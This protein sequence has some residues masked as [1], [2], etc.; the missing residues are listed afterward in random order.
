[1]EKTAQQR[2]GSYSPHLA[3]HSNLLH[4]YV[5]W[6]ASPIRSH[7]R[8]RRKRG[9]QKAGRQCGPG[10]ALAWAPT[11]LD[12]SPSSATN[13]WSS[14]GKMTIHNSGPQFP[15]GGLSGLHQQS[16]R[17]LPAWLFHAWA[18]PSPAHLS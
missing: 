4:V 1:M 9:S 7:P 8:T 15:L 3:P 18:R 5:P 10:R 12:P 11:Q 16:L 6:L 2:E 17:T 13:L 14:P